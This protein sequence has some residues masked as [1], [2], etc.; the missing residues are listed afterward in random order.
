MLLSKNITKNLVE[1]SLLN[2]LGIIRENSLFIAELSRMN[3]PI[4]GERIDNYY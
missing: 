1:Y 3:R 2:N 4:A